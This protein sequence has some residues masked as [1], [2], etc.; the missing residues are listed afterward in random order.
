V[1][2]GWT[3]TTEAT[4]TDPTNFVVPT[5]GIYLITYKLDVRAGSGATPVF[6]TDCAT[7]LTRNGVQIP[8]S[9]TLIEAPETNHVYVM[10]NTIITSL[11]SSDSIALMFWSTDPGTHVG[12]PAFVKGQLPLNNVVPTEAT[13]SIVFTRISST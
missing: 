11:T 13:A 2:N 1:G 3:T 10:T 7:T 12:D 8:G 9:T 6:N 4:Y 5:T